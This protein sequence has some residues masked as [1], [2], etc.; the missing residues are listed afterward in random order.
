MAGALWH[1]P[2]SDVNDCIKHK[3]KP[4]EM[5]DAYIEIEPGIKDSHE[6]DGSIQKVQG[7]KSA[8]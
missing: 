3:R 8:L 2:N 6:P 1:T 4:P 5:Q 7:R